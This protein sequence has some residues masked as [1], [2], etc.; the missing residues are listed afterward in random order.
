MSP[1][2]RPSR[3]PASAGRPRARWR[4]V[5]GQ[6][7]LILENDLFQVTW[8][9]E[10]GGAISSYVHKPTGLDVIWRNA[11]VQP[12]RREVLDQPMAGGSD[13]FDVM[14]GCWY[15][16]LPN[17]FFSGDYFG[18]PVGTHGEM[19]SV[20]WTVEAIEAKGA[21]LR[22][23]MEGRSIRTPLVYRR[24][25]TLRAGRPQL[26]W[27]ETLSNR[28]G[29]D[30]PVAWLHH[31]AFGGPL[32]AGARLIAPARTVQVFKADDPSGMQ[33]ESGYRGRWPHVPEREGGRR[34][35]CSLAPAAGS[36][37]DHSVQLTDFSAGR[38]CLWNEQRQLGFAMGWDPKI[39]P[40]AWSWAYAGGGAT[41]AYPMWNEGLLMTLQ[42]STSPVGRF[43]E[44]V[45]DKKTLIIP[46]RGEVTTEMT[47][48]FVSQP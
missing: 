34:R 20:P 7:R 36:G 38:G 14:D 13:L 18:A 26:H 23:V 2:S 19:R 43:P 30:L 44:L 8:W 42:P 10:Q 16:S 1:P 24:E 3:R 41:T 12:A 28:C 32:L 6:R 29:M 31:A 15:V 33:L 40:Y 27:R 37:L 21:Q 17:G 35:D 4:T 9:P 11:Q 5:A 48:G 39:F 22:V 25:L 45:R 47:T 46:A